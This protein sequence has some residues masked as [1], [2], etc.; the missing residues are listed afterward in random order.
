VIT[1][2]AGEVRFRKP[3]IYQPRDSA[4]WSVNSQFTFQNSE[5]RD[6]HYVLLADNQIGF[7]VVAHDPA[8]PL[9]IDPVLSY[10]TYLGGASNDSGYGIAIGANGNAYVTG[11]TGSVDFPI[12]GGVQSAEGGDFDAFVAKL[13]P[14][15]TALVYS[16]Y[17]GGNGFDRATGIALDGSGNAYVTGTTSSNNFPI[18]TGALQTSFGDGI[19]GTSFCSDAF[20]TKL[21]ASGATLVYSTYLGGSNAD[22][23]QGIAVDD[24][25]SAYV[26]GSTQSGDFPTASPLQAVE[27]GNGDAFVSKLQSN[28]SGLI[29]STFLGGTDSDFGQAIAVNSTGQATV[30]GFTFSTDFPT[31]GPL[32]SSNAGSADAFVATL[33]AAGSALAYSSYLGG[34]GVDRAFAIALDGA[35]GIYLAGDTASPDFP[36]SVGAFQS[37]MGAGTCG[38]APCADAFVTKLT[39]A[40]STLGY[41]TYLGGVDVEQATGIAVNASGSVFV[42][43]FTRSDDF[44]VLDALQATFG[45]GTCGASPCSDA[46]V[47]EL[48]AAGTSLAYSTFL[49]G[50]TTD[51]AQGIAVDAADNAYV[52]GSTSSPNFPATVGAVQ[53]LR[54]ANA[55]TG[56]AFVAKIAT[57]D[58]PAVALSPQ[59]L[60]FADQSVGFESAAQTVTLTNSGS[61][62]LSI[63][64]ITASSEF[65]QTNTCGGS[66]PA[67][68]GTCSINVTFTPADTGERTG[69]LTIRD[70]AV[71]SP[72]VLNL[73]GNGVTPA[74]LVTLSPSE[75]TFADEKVGSASA[76]QTVTLTN[77]GTAELTITNITLGSTDF[78]QTNDCGTTLAVGASC[79]ISV[80]FAPAKTGALADQVSVADDA[81]GSPHTV[82]LSG[83]GIAVFSLSADSTSTTIIRGADTATFTVGAS[84]PSDFTD[85]ITLSCANAAGA[86]CTFSPEAITPGENSTLT[87]SGLASAIS[88]T[89]LIEVQ[90]TSGSQSA[91][92]DLTILFSDFS[93]SANPTYASIAAGDSVTI[94][95]TLTPS[96]GFTGNATFGCVGL[97]AESSCSFSPD[98][99]NLDGT[100]AA[101]TTVTLKT[102]ER[103][104]TRTPPPPWRPLGWL[105]GLVLLAGVVKFLPMARRGALRWVPLAP[106]LLLIALFL[107]SCTNYY[108]TIRGSLPGTYSVGIVATSDITTHTTVVILNVN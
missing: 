82:I 100:N 41:S 42:T 91:L 10:S 51:F 103:V 80:T 59:P 37:A 98:S 40:G 36:I 1:L 62:P 18:T 27:G 19:C 66:V 2:E 72:H 63:T 28:G 33:N 34:S 24:A 107:G 102:A 17:L 108:Q 13:D 106:A 69:T 60:T 32:Q 105:L 55:P 5:L 4:S 78:T 45:G 73:S 9:I 43:G 52:T 85:S 88:T 12:A 21:D 81:T 20:V 15:G 22:S 3:L 71:G 29:Y 95:L 77:S 14:T 7:E 61:A 104:T 38:S 76:A 68:G 96:N 53:P 86:T 70:N 99:V 89:I 84:A 46:F 67:G 39:S 50:N 6:G 65:A 31:V 93:L 58:A 11:S 57:L 25:G 48:N 90:G 64:D 49:G 26:T 54:G 74:P 8:R 101:T 44:P 16:T 56:D 47:S 35:G 92:L 97:P 23:G 83:N 79:T 94:T 30:V 75:L 87:V